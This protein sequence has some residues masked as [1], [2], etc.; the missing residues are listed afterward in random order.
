MM[1]QRVSRGRETDLTYFCMMRPF[2]LPAVSD[3]ASLRRLCNRL[4]L[5]RLPATAPGGIEVNDKKYF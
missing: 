2:S 3:P 1:C 5:L 4:R